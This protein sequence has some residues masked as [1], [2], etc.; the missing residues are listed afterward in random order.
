MNVTI[1]GVLERIFGDSYAVDVVVAV[2]ANARAVRTTTAIWYL[3]ALSVFFA[4]LMKNG[5]IRKAP[6]AILTRN[7]TRAAL[8]L[9]VANRIRHDALFM[10]GAGFIEFDILQTS[11]AFQV[12]VCAKRTPALALDTCCEF[13]GAI[14]C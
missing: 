11:V 2:I 8:A 13:H 1:P 3:V 10:I 9:L 14:C 7:V 6:L 4:F 5:R 12:W